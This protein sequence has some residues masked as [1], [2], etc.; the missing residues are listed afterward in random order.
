MFLASLALKD[1]RSCS[2]TKIHLHKELT[3]IV[4]ENNSGKSNIL[5][6]MRL[7]VNPLNGK[8]DRYAEENDVCRIDSAD[9]FKLEAVYKDISD[10][11]KAL[12]IAGCPD[13]TKDEV[14]RLSL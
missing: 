7:L 4:G 6:A 3:I 14:F 8:R 9:G 11:Q 10:D 2:E 5:E 1:F 12:M 13:P